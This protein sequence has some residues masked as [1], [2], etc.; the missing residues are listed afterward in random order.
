MAITMTVIRQE[1]GQMEIGKLQDMTWIVAPATTGSSALPTAASLTFAEIQRKSTAELEATL[2]A[3]RAE[4]AARLAAHR[5]AGA[6]G[7]C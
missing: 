2:S 1:D 5:A 3:I 7:C 6:Q 4:D